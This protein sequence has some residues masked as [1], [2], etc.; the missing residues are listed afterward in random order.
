M[1]KLY[2]LLGV[3]ALLTVVAAPE[4]GAARPEVVPAAAPAL[5]AAPLSLPAPALAASGQDG[6]YSTTGS[7]WN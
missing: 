7:Q 2:L 3:L 4:A 6:G 5:D 1:N